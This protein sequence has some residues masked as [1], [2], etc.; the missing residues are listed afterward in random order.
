[1]S[2]KNLCISALGSQVDTERTPQFF[3]CIMRWAL[4]ISELRGPLRGI[5]LRPVVI[6]QKLLKTKAYKQR[7]SQFLMRIGH[8][9]IS[10][11]HYFY[12]N[13]ER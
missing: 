5:P 6:G 9:I 7:F 2:S 10:W 4:D 13:I 12:F 3:Q 8:I 1:M 11:T